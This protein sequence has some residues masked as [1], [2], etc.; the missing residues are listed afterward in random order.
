VNGAFLAYAMFIFVIWGLQEKLEVFDHPE[1]F[2]GTRA[3]FLVLQLLLALI[4]VLIVVM[5]LIS[6]IFTEAGGSVTNGIAHF[7]G[8]I[9]GLLVLLVYDVKTACRRYFDAVLGISI[10][11]GIV[12]Y[13][14]YLMN[15]A[16]FVKSG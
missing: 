2:P 16:R 11:I 4:L 5:A 12:G 15:L 3:R 8:F 6:G 9:T 1:V 13:G 7:G 14:F 10:L